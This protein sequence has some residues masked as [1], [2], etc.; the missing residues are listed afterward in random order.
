MPFEYIIETKLIKTLISKFLN[1]PLYQNVTL[2]CLTVIVGLAPGP[3]YD[4]SFVALFSQTML[5]IEQMLPLDT[6]IKEAFAMGNNFKQSFIQN[7]AIF[8]CTTLRKHRLLMERRELGNNLKALE[9]LL[10]ISEVE[11]IET[12]KTC[13]KYWN[14]LVADLYHESNIPAVGVVGNAGGTVFISSVRRFIYKTVLSRLRYLII[15]RMVKPEDVLV[16]ENERGEVVRDFKDSDSSDLYRS[17]RETLVYLTHLD[18]RA[19]ERIMVRKLLDQAKES[20][21]SLKNL[22]VLCWAIGS[23]SGAMDVED[24][25][26]LLVFVIKELLNLGVKK[27]GKTNKAIVAS[28]LMYVIVQYPRLLRAH[29]KL[30][31]PVV[32]KLFEFMVDTRDVIQVYLYFMNKMSNTKY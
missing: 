14:T 17:M 20:E 32:N 6:N 26:R 10:L 1:V 29:W 4:D 5:K 23:V 22:S 8:L 12:C 21:W 30:L 28:N 11:E 31:K 3:Q 13:L 15:S 2:K 19:T 9:Y 25:K 27:E 24:E 7:L 18:S 16:V